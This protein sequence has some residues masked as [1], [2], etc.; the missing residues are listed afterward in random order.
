MNQVGVR[1]PDFT[2]VLVLGFDKFE[3]ICDDPNF[4]DLEFREL[5]GN[6]RNSNDAGALKTVESYTE[7]M[8]KLAVT[9]GNVAN[10]GK[11]KKL[12]MMM[13][14]EEVIVHGIMIY[15]D[16]K[17]QVYWDSWLLFLK[18]AY[19]LMIPLR[20]CW[21]LTGGGS[22]DAEPPDLKDSFDATLAIE[23]IY[24]STSA[25]GACEHAKRALKGSQPMRAK[26]ALKERKASPVQDERAVASSFR[27]G[28]PVQDELAVAKPVQDERAVAFAA[29]SKANSLK[30]AIVLAGST[31][32]AT[33]IASRTLRTTRAAW[34]W[35]STAR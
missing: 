20:I 16:N 27:K 7:T 10:T 6:F 5:G 31:W 33:R 17:V 9:A 13:Q 30:S 12:Q 4:A 14:K 35:W 8:K 22:K 32:W 23:Y 19:C 26:R 2:E 29:S 18:T 3:L 1:A 28:K 11:N 25:T 15:P 24:Y 34:R 21:N